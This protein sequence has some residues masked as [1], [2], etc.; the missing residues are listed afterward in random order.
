MKNIVFTV[1]LC[2]VASELAAAPILSVQPQTG[3][4]AQEISEEMSS[5][6]G[7]IGS[8]L[9][10]FSLAD[11]SGVVGRVL[12]YPPGPINQHSAAGVVD[13]YKES[14]EAAGGVIDSVSRTKVNGFHAY[15]FTGK[16]GEV[17]LLSYAVYTS[18]RVVMVMLQR[19]GEM[20][21]DHPAV[22]EYLGRIRFSPGV[23]GGRI[24]AIDRE[25]AGYKIGYWLGTLATPILLVA[26]PIAVFVVP[27][28]IWRKLK[29]K[30][31]QPGAT[32]NPGNAQ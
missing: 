32:D 18:D 7:A 11:D 26:L 14:V 25:S 30:T 13:G 4:T 15:Q 19:D 3:W 8:E 6:L 23:T 24:D 31:A 20:G 12:Q 1:L 17:S 21:P 28:W 9:L 22:V 16:V 10:D 5:Q 2:V 29:K 27:G